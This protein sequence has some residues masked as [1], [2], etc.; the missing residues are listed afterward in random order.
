[1]NALWSVLKR[2][3]RMPDVQW[4]E[5]ADY[6]TLEAVLTGWIIEVRMS[7]GGTIVGEVMRLCEVYW[8]NA[9][10]LAPY[11]GDDLGYYNQDSPVVVDLD[12]VEAIII[13]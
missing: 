9:L 11:A 4:A 3:A 7:G 12:C 2:E 5:N 6:D 8:G 1:M 10:K 13:Q